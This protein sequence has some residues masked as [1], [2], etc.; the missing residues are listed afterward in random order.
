MTLVNMWGSL[1]QRLRNAADIP[2]GAVDHL[3]LPGL[4]RNE[5]CAPCWKMKQS[6]VQFYEA[7]RTAVPCQRP[8]LSSLQLRSAQLRARRAVRE[9]YEVGRTPKMQG[10]FLKAVSLEA[11]PDNLHLLIGRRVRSWFNTTPTRLRERWDLAREILLRAP[12]SVRWPFLKTVAGGWTTTDRMHVTD[13]RWSCVFGC[14]RRPDSIEHYLRCPRLVHLVCRPRAVAPPCPLIRLGLGLPV[15][16]PAFDLTREN[17]VLA[18]SLSFYIYHI[19][20][21]M[22]GR[23]QGRPLDLSQS[24]VALKSAL[25][26]MPENYS[27]LPP[28]PNAARPYS[29]L[30]PRRRG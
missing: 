28:P 19:A 4:I 27:I 13:E 22:A 17:A 29:W 12:A 14:F 25:T 3:P 24:L 11:F 21:E 10:V 26:K 15:H 18:T 8:S 23:Q 30:R 16:Y 6:I 9:A 20:K 5:L 1:L 2:S 7:L